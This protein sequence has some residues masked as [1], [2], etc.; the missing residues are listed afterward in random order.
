M[1]LDYEFPFDLD[2]SPEAVNLIEQLLK[3]LPEERLGA[4]K[5]GS[6]NDISCLMSH[7]YFKQID[8]E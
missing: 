4:G 5:P 1:T 8:F 2:I 3:L 7:P 6:A